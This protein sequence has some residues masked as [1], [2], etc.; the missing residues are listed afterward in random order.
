MRTST[1]LVLSIV[2]L[3]F[4]TS[5]NT[6]YNQN[7]IWDTGANS[8]PT[9]TTLSATALIAIRSTTSTLGYSHLYTAVIKITIGGLV[10]GAILK[11]QYD[12][13][14]P[15]STG[16]TKRFI[17][18]VMRQLTQSEYDFLFLHMIAELTELFLK[19]YIKPITRNILLEYT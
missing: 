10:N 19:I 15:V 11:T 13:S 7:I 4:G 16:A 1:I 6:F 8:F 5:L 2:L 14:G 12:T 9:G 18:V 17:R 3:L